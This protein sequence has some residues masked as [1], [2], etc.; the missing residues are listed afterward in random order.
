MGAGAAILIIL[1]KYLDDVVI[2]PTNISIVSVNGQIIESSG[3]ATLNLVVK[4]SDASS[5][6]VC[7]YRY[8][9][10]SLRL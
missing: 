7:D 3:Q 2:Y 1:K 10:T 6:D 4:T 5:P 9:K 8:N